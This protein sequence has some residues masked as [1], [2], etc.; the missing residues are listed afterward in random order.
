MRFI[1]GSMPLL[2]ETRLNSNCLQTTIVLK[3]ALRQYTFE[4]R[5][6]RRERKRNQSLQ[7]PKTSKCFEL[8]RRSSFH[9]MCLPLCFF[10]LWC[11]QSDVAWAACC[12]C[13]GCAR[14]RYLAVSNCF[15]L[16]ADTAFFVKVLEQRQPI[17]QMAENALVCTKKEANQK[18]KRV[19]ESPITI[20]HGFINY[21]R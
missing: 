9:T 19:T 3:V 5:H 21:A 8:A 16:Q 11:A 17:S 12:W 7:M 2:N 20:P 18:K 13:R 15:V 4:T 6:S 1:Y 14:T 10:S